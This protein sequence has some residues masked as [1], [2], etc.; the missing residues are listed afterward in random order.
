MG[1]AR[2]RFASSSFCTDE[3]QPG[4]FRQFRRWVIILARKSAFGTRGSRLN[5][6]TTLLRRSVDGA[7]FPRRQQEILTNESP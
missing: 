3:V 4:S 6:S 7:K 1:R 2:V 5:V